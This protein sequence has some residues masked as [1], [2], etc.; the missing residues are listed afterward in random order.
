[1]HNPKNSSG[2]SLH[3]CVRVSDIEQ[4][5]THQK[6]YRLP[7]GIYAC[8]S[9]GAVVFLDARQDR[10]Y[11][12]AGVE[13]VRLLDFIEFSDLDQCPRDA[14][15]PVDIKR[16]D[17]LADT[18][19]RRGLLCRASDESGDEGSRVPRQRL[20]PPQIDPPLLDVVNTRSPRLGDMANF[21]FACLRAAW[22]LRW[23]SLGAIASGVTHARRDNGPNALPATLELARVF[24]SLQCWF[25]SRRNR[26]LFN[27]LSLVYFLQRYEHFPHFVIGVQT[28]PFAAHAWV[29][30]DGIVLDG[31][32]ENVGHFA[33]IL[34][35]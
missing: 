11:G 29:Q 13:I 12:M 28:A 14:N 15:P 25:F 16:L 3:E 7:R 18:L 34:V 22:S 32:P 4:S 21:L 31:D 23:Y 1:M 9:Q 19:I 30:R 24:Q 17:R 35:A 26:C 8:R 33:P 6:R 20:A 27:A 10:Y 5:G 2:E